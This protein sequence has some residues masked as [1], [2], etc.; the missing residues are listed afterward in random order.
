MVERYPSRGFEFPPQ[1]NRCG[2]GVRY[3]D[4][5]SALGQLERRGIE[6]PPAS[7]EASSS[8]KNAGQ[9][10]PSE[11]RKDCL[12]YKSRDGAEESYFV[13]ETTRD[14]SPAT[15]LDFPPGTNLAKGDEVEVSGFVLTNPES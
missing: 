7:Q 1:Q 4:K 14:C 12:H 5:E 11:C 13:C 2:E 8:N 10:F 6:K 9:I 15:L 3:F